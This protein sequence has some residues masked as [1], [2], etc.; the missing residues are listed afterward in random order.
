MHDQLEFS[1]LDKPA[2]A[3]K[4]AQLPLT[5]APE[6]EPAEP[7][8][9]Q[10]QSDRLRDLLTA[11]S[12][13]Q[14]HLR[15]T[16]NTSTMMSVRFDT[17]GRAARLSLHRMFL[18]A[19]EEV[20]RALAHWVKHP[21]GRKYAGLLNA[22][23]R[24]RRDQIAPKAPR[25]VPLRVEGSVYNL[26]TLYDEVNREHFAGRITAAI[27]WGKMPVTGRR[28]RSIRFGSYSPGE[29]LIRMHPL[30]DQ[31]FVPAYFVRYIVFH[32]MLHADL[33]IEELPSGR[34]AI[35]PPIFKQR[36]QAYPEYARALA[37]MENPRNLKHL[38]R[39]R[40]AW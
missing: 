30:L 27:T 35:H 3:P 28:R 23:I 21:R 12:G 22:F 13:L 34:R 32:E 29:H 5:P 19:P 4:R 38:L 10:A 33:G 11:R 36:E 18:D 15:I 26:R 8:S 20:E 16:N 24:E 25:I 39:G 40:T 6:P 7:P 9:L 1:W 2:A 37:W 17:S 31:A 14:I